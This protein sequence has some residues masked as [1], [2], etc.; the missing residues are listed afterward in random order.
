MIGMPRSAGPLRRLRSMLRSRL[1]SGGRRPTTSRRSATRP[2]PRSCLSRAQR[3]WRH[4]DDHQAAAPGSNSGGP[5]PT[6]S[7]PCSPAPHPRPRSSPHSPARRC[8][9]TSRAAGAGPMPGSRQ[10]QA[11]SSS[12]SA[13]ASLLHI[14]HYGVVRRVAADLALRDQ[15]RLGGLPGLSPYVRA[16]P[17]PRALTG[18]FGASSHVL[19][20][21]LQAFLRF[22]VVCPPVLPLRPPSSG[23]PFGRRPLVP[24]LRPSLSGS[25]P[26]RFPSGFPSP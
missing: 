23:F 6:A 25:V 17:N 11:R 3:P 18:R 7:E 19:R 13:V 10:Q 4:R 24:S 21:P 20:S 14:G 1:C 22:P 8:P 5:E 15:G 16:A 26:L 12:V 9:A 2:P